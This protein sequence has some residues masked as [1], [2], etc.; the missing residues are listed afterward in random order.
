MKKYAVAYMSFFDNDLQLYTVEATT[1]KEALVK[2][3]SENNHPELA[4][5]T[6]ES[7]ADDIEV[8]KEIAFGGDWVFEVKEL[9]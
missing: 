6:H 4:G 1:W 5:I 3:L 8:V 7:L 2:A 9:N